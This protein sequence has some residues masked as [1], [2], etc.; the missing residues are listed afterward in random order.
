MR[1]ETLLALALILL[2][3]VAG[4]AALTAEPS[5]RILG[6]GFV[7]AVPQAAPRLEQSD[8][9]PARDERVSALY[10]RCAIRPECC[11]QTN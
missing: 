9:Q 4:V 10:S 8:G 11:A 5:T 6:H 3:A 2:V 7:R 1:L